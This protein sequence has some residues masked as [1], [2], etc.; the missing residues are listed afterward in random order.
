MDYYI[1]SFILINKNNELNI[2]HLNSQD[3]QADL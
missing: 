1:V 2:E 3:S